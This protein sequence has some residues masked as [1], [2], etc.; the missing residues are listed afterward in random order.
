MTEGS[1]IEEQKLR[2][3][4]EVLKLN[5]D[6]IEVEEDRSLA[7]IERKLENCERKLDEIEKQKDVVREEKL[8]NGETVAQVKRWGQQIADEVKV[9]DEPMGNL[10]REIRELKEKAT[11][12]REESLNGNHRKEE[13]QL[14]QEKLEMRANF[15]KKEAENRQKSRRM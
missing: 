3:K 5:L 9:A 10:K 2:R 12:E 7:K 6:D 8:E 1:D 4:I 15:N 14:E 11:R 13:L